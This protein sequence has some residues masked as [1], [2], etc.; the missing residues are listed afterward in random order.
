MAI[1]GGKDHSIIVILDS[2]T[3]NEYD[4]MKRNDALHISSRYNM[5]QFVLLWK[6]QTRSAFRFTQR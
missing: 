1:A 3:S 6:C 5:A 4:L 2:K